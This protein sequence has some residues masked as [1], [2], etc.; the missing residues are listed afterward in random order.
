MLGVV[1]QFYNRYFSDEEAVVLLLIFIL[2][3][4]TIYYFGR[5]LAPVIASLIIAY[6]LAPLVEKLNQAKVPYNLATIIIW[7]LFT[8]L[9]LLSIF[10]LMPLV[11]GQVSNLLSEAPKML[12]QLQITILTLPDQ[13]PELISKDL[14]AQW[15]SYLSSAELGQTLTNLAPQVVSFSLS[16]IPNL[17]AAMIYL[18]IVPIMVFFL[19]KDRDALWT[20][21]LKTLPNRRSLMNKI[22]IE[23]NQQI[24]NYIRGKVIEIIIVGGVS[25][26]VFKILGLNY[27]V[28]LAILVG[29][30]VLI[31]YIG[32]LVV[33]IPIAIIA[34][35]QW[36]FTSDFYYVIIAY[37][38]IQA[39]DGNVLVPLLFSEAV[40]LHPLSIIIAVLI[41]GG[42][43]GF[44]GVF[45]AIP[46]ATLFKAVV[47]SWPQTD[48]KKTE[49]VEQV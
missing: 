18:V 1:K 20:R 41:F 30:S 3:G 2:S 47:N 46:L 34:M 35:F 17:L 11:V 7:L 6:I 37:T 31:P 5:V 24:A 23:M 22:A 26:I 21:L 38:I 9:L 45:F 49:P 25:F 29:V 33:T 19:L 16:T 44:W 28:L 42:L 15:M 27:A 43:W 48:T 14:A 39:L 4:L 8:G 13:F 12:Q 40:N 32:A 36:G 10:G